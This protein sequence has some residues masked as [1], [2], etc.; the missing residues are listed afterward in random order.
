MRTVIFSAAMTIGMTG[1]A[2]I[3]LPKIDK[4]SVD[5]LTMYTCGCFCSSESEVV[6]GEINYYMTF[7]IDDYPN[8]EIE[9]MEK[10]YNKLME[11]LQLNGH[12]V[13]DPDVIQV[14]D[15]A[16]YP[17]LKDIKTKLRIGFCPEERFDYIIK[18]YVVSLIY[19]STEYQLFIYKN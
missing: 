19:S 14:S 11:V 4:Y 16:T 8:M 6:L 13:M 5:G 15:Y 9:Y 1:N 12:D 2:Q 18:G 10:V 3:K 7:D 17:N